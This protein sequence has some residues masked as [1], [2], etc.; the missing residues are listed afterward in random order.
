MIRKILITG[1]SGF[2]GKNFLN[3]IKKKKYKILAISRK[4]HKKNKNIAWLKSDFGKV[5]VTNLKKIIKFGPEV[6]IHLAWQDI[7]NFDKKTC[8]L[9]LKKS[10]NF[11]RKLIY[12]KSLKKIIITGSCL[13]YL[14]K[15]GIVNE[16]QKLDKINFMSKSKI[17]LQVFSKKL[18]IKNKKKFYWL[19][20]FYIYGPHQRKDSLIPYLVKKISNNSDV[21][22]ANPFKNLD[23]VYVQDFAKIM[24]L[25]VR[26]NIK[27]GIYNV[28][29]GIKTSVREIHDNLQLKIKKKC[30]P[31]KY[32][33][34]NYFISNNLKLNKIIGKY[35]FINIDKGLNKYLLWLKKSNFF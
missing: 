6:M 8:V 19:R 12:L 5:N 31:N 4:N 28:G 25:F 22:L 10:K 16:N 20:P 29:S 34:T 33:R 15:K 13:E 2:V 23:Y 1:A 26:K 9:N 24:E 18:C 14:N 3:L 17:D 35:K 11:L 30:I 21:K 27:E 7:P 32:S